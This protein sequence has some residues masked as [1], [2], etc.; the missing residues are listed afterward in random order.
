MNVQA[1]INEIN[2]L[3]KTCESWDIID[4]AGVAFV[5]AADTVGGQYSMTNVSEEY[6][7]MFIG[8]IRGMLC[9]PASYGLSNETIAWFNARGI[10]G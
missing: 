6:A 10:K 3:A 2:E 5:N 1:I 4:A 9:D 7:E 8:T